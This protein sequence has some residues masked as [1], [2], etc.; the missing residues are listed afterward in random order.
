MNVPDSVPSGLLAMQ[1]PVPESIDWRVDPATGMN[2]LT[3]VHNQHIPNYCGACWSFAATASFGDR[4]NILL[5]HSMATNST[6]VLQTSLGMQVILNCDK[7]SNGCHGGDPMTAYKYISEHGLPDETCQAYVARG[8]DTGNTCT[9][10]DKCMTCN[11]EGVCSAEKEYKEWTISEYGKV[12]NVAHMERELMRGPISCCLHVNEEFEA[13]QDFTIFVDK[14]DVKE[15]NHCISLVGYGMDRV[16]GMEYWI[17]RN[18]WGD[19]WANHGFFRIRKGFN[20]LGIEDW[21][22]YAVPARGGEPRIHTVHSALSAPETIRTESR[23]PSA[24]LENYT[25]QKVRKT[26]QV[27][28]HF[29]DGNIAR[30]ALDEFDW[31]KVLP[32]SASR[33]QRIPKPCGSCWAHAV[34]AV[35]SDRQIIKSK[36][37]WPMANLSPQVLLNCQWGGSCSGGD[38]LAAY[39]SIQAHK[40]IPDDTCQTY[41]GSSSAAP[42]CDAI[43]VCEECF[44]GN[45]TDTFWPGTCH[46][47][48]KFDKF[49]VSEAYDIPAVEEEIKFEILL[50]GPIS[51]GIYATEAFHNYKGGV[52][53]EKAPNPD[54]INHEIEVVGWGLD[55][56]G[57]KYWIGRN[58]WGTAWGEDGWFRMKIGD[59]DMNLSKQCTAGKPINAS[60]QHRRGTFMT[61]ETQ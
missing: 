6:R 37:R 48:N 14:G 51:C 39:Q 15:P 13:T 40:G 29:G 7:G 17:G 33:N 25:V 11:G 36:G 44:A 2:L 24:S 27:G 45:T 42:T 12:N 26:K 8:W 20:D 43:H 54:E 18:S 9:D 19:Y 5:G 22:S 28:V 59:S 31:R 21:C 1:G 60:N 4:V 46:V 32:L 30:L 41:A 35:L 55:E 3:R 49:S 34:T 57:T 23:G 52:Y 50:N 53:E 58:S 38:A 47:I 16:S 61:S 56:D 10:V